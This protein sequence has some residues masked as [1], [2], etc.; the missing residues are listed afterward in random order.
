MCSIVQ[1]ILLVF[2]SQPYATEGKLTF[3]KG[4]VLDNSRVNK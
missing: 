3:S 2:G 1:A 4:M